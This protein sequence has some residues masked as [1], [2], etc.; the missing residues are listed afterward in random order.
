MDVLLLQSRWQC[1]R[2]AFERLRGATGLASLVVFTAS[3]FGAACVKGGGEY[4]FRHRRRLTRPLYGN[5][6][7]PACLAA[8]LRAEV[9]GDGK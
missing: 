8:A 7:V 1:E 6:F 9:S 3:L 5:N 2:V 4:A